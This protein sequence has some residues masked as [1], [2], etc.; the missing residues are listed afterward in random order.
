MGYERTNEA[1]RARWKDFLE[2]LVIAFLWFPLHGRQLAGIF[3][4]SGHVDVGDFAGYRR[5]H[6]VAFFQAVKLEKS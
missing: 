2:W 4:A 6:G 5:G 1:P 3:R